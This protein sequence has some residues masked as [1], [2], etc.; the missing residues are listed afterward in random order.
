MID[1]NVLKEH[2]EAIEPGQRIDLKD[3]NGET[4]TEITKTQTGF[5]IGFSQAGMSYDGLLNISK[6]EIKVDDG[7]LYMFA[8]GDGVI[9]TA[10][11]AIYP[12]KYYSMEVR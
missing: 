5:F 6:P 9:A 7:N 8:Y 1:I 2:I 3:L 10:Y 12:G 11:L 4:I